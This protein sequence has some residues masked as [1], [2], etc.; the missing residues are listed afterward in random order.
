MDWQF[1]PGSKGYARFAQERLPVDILATAKDTVGASCPFDTLPAAGAT[2]DLEFTGRDYLACFH[3]QVVV[4]P[5][6]REDGMILQRA[7]SATY[8][9]R[10]RTWR[11][12]LDNRI[13]FQKRGEAHRVEAVVLN[14]S[15]EGLFLSTTTA[16]AINDA[17]DLLLTLPGNPGYRVL[18]RVVRVDPVIPGCFGVLFVELSSEAK[19]A[20]TYF[21]WDRLRTLYPGE[22]KALWPG[23]RRRVRRNIPSEETA[24]E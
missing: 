17:L 24:T 20:L 23:S 19:R 10:R 21:M 1:F 6:A 22:I 12:S 3:M 15:C 4:E 13:V 7:A 5:T 8:A 16:L 18:G 9:Q 14:L 2:V 11:V